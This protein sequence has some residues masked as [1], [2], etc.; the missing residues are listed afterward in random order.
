MLDEVFAFFIQTG[1]ESKPS[2]LFV[3]C[4]DDELVAVI[5]TSKDPR[6]DFLLVDRETDVEAVK[7]NRLASTRRDEN[8]GLEVPAEAFVF[9]NENT[10]AGV[11]DHGIA[12][13]GAGNVGNVRKLKHEVLLR[14][15][16]EY[17]STL[18]MTPRAPKEMSQT[19]MKSWPSSRGDAAQA[20]AIRVQPS[21]T[22]S[23]M[24]TEPLLDEVIPT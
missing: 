10:R 17:Q 24:D 7:P 15:C 21:I 19:K 8:N 9:R 1:L 16:A 11:P 23:I 14:E 2:V 22:L 3:L 4:N 5:T 13:D 12:I 18:R 6:M 20:S